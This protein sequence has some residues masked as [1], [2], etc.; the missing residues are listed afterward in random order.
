MRIIL[1]LRRKLSQTRLLRKLRFS[2][3]KD[4][5]SPS[6]DELIEEFAKGI[7]FHGPIEDTCI[8][9]EDEASE[10]VLDETLLKEMEV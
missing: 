3:F 2:N 4:E 8:G 9:V 5:S 7:I 6:M 10:E 1:R